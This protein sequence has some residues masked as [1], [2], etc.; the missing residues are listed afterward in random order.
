MEDNTK[1]YSSNGYDYRANDKGQILH[2]EGQLRLEEGERNSYAQRVAGGEY[3]H[4][5]DDG[6]HLIGTRFGGSGELDNIVAEDRYVNRG[7]FKSLENEWAE[8][9][10]Q[11]NDVYVEIDPVYHGDSQRPD[12]ITAKTE[13]NDGDKSTVDYFS[14]TNENL[15]TDEFELPEEASEMM[16]TWGGN[17][18]RESADV[19]L[20]YNNMDNSAIEEAAD[21]KSESEYVESAFA[22]DVDLSTSESVDSTAS[23]SV[24][25]TASESADSTASESVES[26]TSES[27][28]SSP[29]VSMENSRGE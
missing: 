20:S 22:E 8:N 12:V 23:E 15:E 5:N 10:E 1:E 7:A 18:I 17:P 21:Y 13:I 4:E 16:D 6:G 24:D 9:I 25:S 19:D 26:T 28:E 2:A 27:V 3:R 14:V 11:G 29:S